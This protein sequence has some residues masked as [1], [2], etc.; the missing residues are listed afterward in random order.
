VSV[1][2]EHLPS[3]VG[4]RRPHVICHV[5]LRRSHVD[6]WY[7]E[8]WKSDDRSRRCRCCG[9][10]HVVVTCNTGGKSNQITLSLVH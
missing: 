10:Y 5:Q 7:S 9:K 4:Y 2:D 8:W 3:G 6:D 1:S